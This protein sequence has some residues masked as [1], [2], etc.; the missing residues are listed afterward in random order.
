MIIVNRNKDLKKLLKKLEE[1]KS[2][3][4]IQAFHSRGTM[5]VLDMGQKTEVT[6]GGKIY[7]HG[8]KTIVVENYTWELKQESNEVVDSTAVESEIRRGIPILVGKSI[9]DIKIDK[10]DGIRVVIIFT[11]GFRLGIRLSEKKERDIGI[12]LHSGN[13]IDVGFDGQWQE[14]TGDHVD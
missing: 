5:F 14:V 10:D 2:E 3:K 11:D 7:I 4:V 6:S 13:W 9:G 12:R 8:E 1:L